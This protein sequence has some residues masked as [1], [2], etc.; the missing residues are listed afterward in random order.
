MTVDL[1][2]T[3]MLNGIENSE[4]GI[5]DYKVRLLPLPFSASVEDKA[6]AA[7]RERGTG[8]M[9]EREGGGRREMWVH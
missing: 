3:A 1:L 9:K 6:G 4:S 5:F 8:G 7:G 2:A